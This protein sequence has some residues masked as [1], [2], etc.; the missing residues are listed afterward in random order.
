M[1]PDQLHVIVVQVAPFDLLSSLE[2]LDVTARHPQPI[3]DE[4]PQVVGEGLQEAS[5]A[6]KILSMA[7]SIKR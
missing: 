7:N 6:L 5:G 4:A 2:P 3:L 1:C